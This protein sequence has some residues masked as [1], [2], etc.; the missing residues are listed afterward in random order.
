MKRMLSAAMAVMMG[1][2]AAMAGGHLPDALTRLPHAPSTGVGLA[3]IRDRLAQAYGEDHLFEIRNP[4]DGGFTVVIELPFES[5][6]PDAI[7]A[8]AENEAEQVEMTFPASEPA[9]ALTRQDPRPI[10]NTP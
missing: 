4:A 6:E 3:N 7:P 10:G 1:A 8:P 5:A 9:P 2:T